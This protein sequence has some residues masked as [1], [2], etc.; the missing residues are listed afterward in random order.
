MLIIWCCI[1]FISRD[2]YVKRAIRV[3]KSAPITKAY[4][5]STL[6][7]ADNVCV[8]LKGLMNKS[9]STENGFSHEVW[10][11]AVVFHYSDFFVSLFI[12]I[13]NFYLNVKG[14]QWGLFRFLSWSSNTWVYKVL[15]A[16]NVGGTLL[17]SW[18]PHKLITATVLYPICDL[19]GN[20]LHTFS[21]YRCAKIL[22]LGFQ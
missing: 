14:Q 3:F 11:C 7:T 2:G 8:I 5:F 9:L 22:F 18:P 10:E 1:L 4:D 21:L 12:W 19:N 17:C 13:I 20:N 16:Y 15:M 6:E